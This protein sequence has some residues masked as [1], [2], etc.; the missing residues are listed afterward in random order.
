MSQEQEF[1]AL[2]PKP[3]GYLPDREAAVTYVQDAGVRFMKA[4]SQCLDPE[5]EMFTALMGAAVVSIRQGMLEAGK[6]VSR[7]NVSTVE[8][9]ADAGNRAA[10]KS[11]LI[12]DAMQ[13]AGS[14]M[15]RD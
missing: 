8:A 1:L 15:T 4:L 6:V 3:E 5:T 12:D 7:H 2:L 11:K 9:D 10:G 13:E 14:F